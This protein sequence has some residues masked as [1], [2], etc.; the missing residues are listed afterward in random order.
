MLE[1]LFNP[2]IMSYVKVF[3]LFGLFL[4][5]FVIISKTINNLLS[6]RKDKIRTDIIDTVKIFGSAIIIA[7]VLFMFIGSLFLI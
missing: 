7:L 5:L 2:Y 3:A 4:L 1:Q 6:K